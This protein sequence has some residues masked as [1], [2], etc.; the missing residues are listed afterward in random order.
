MG[1]QCINNNKHCITQTFHINMRNEGIV[2]TCDGLGSGL[3]FTVRVLQL[4]ITVE[5]KRNN[6]LNVAL[7]HYT[8]EEKRLR[9]TS[10]LKINLYLTQKGSKLI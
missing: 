8:R 10:C 4:I 5:R 6:G 1:L 9:V 7:V 2:G 3:F